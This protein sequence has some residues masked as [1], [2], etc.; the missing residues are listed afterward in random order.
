MQDTDPIDYYE[1][2]QISP[3]ADPDLIHRVYRLLA[4][5]F[6]PDNGETGNAG[7]F[8][9]VHEAY[10]V[11]SD[12]EKR[13]EYDVGYHQ[14]KGT[15]V[16]LVSSAVRAEND[17]DYEQAVR[18]TVLEV[19]Y[20]TRRNDPRQPG[21]FDRDLEEMIGRPMEQL[22]F[23]FWYLT[24]R[25]LVK[26]GEESRLMITV[27]GVDY[28]ERHFARPNGRSNGGDNKQLRERSPS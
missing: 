22:Q 21:V 8:R 23:T 17:F 11:L 24:Q 15:R 7:R 16:K 28:L 26:R 14:R 19:L 2:L 27:E 4:Q 25:N 9:E 1:T 20:T 12:P 18:L 13:A 3:N 5:R 6:H 10:T